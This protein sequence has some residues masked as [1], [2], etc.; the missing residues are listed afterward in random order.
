MAQRGLIPAWDS[1]EIRQVY[2]NTMEYPE[3]LEYFFEEGRTSSVPS[4]I[5]YAEAIDI[6]EDE[7]A[8]YLLQEKSLA[9][10]EED[11]REAIEPLVIQ[12]NPDEK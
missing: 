8:L 1:D 7:I 11:I 12:E 5:S 6:V 10:C 4:D 9:E 2:M 3:H